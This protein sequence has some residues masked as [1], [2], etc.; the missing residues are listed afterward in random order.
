MSTYVDAGFTRKHLE[1]GDTVVNVLS[2]E[3]YRAKRIPGSVSIPFEAPD[4]ERR[5]QERLPDKS[6]P[7]IVHCSGMDCQASTKAARRLESL[8]YKQ[9]HDFKAG[10]AGWEQAG[11]AF[12]SGEQKAAQPAE[13]TTPGR[14]PRPGRDRA[15]RHEETRARGVQ[16]V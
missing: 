10:L 4:F 5:A 16:K 11:N 8:G 6:K 15:S 12:E 1:Q 3:Q 2:A 9:V 7:V 14:P 13:A